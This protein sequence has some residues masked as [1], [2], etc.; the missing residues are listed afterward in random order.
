[1]KEEIIG[2]RFTRVQSDRHKLYFEDNWEPIYARKPGMVYTAALIFCDE[3]SIAISPS[4]GGGKA[5][6]PE[7]FN[8]FK[9]VN[10]TEGNDPI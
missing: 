6:C 2:Y 10:F 8:N 4:G 9:L 5:L 3:C 1:M 7:C